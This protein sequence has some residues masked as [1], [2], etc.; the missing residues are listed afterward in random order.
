VERG[1]LELE[2]AIGT[3]CGE[4][5]LERGKRKG[6]DRIREIMDLRNIRGEEML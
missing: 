1:L 4:L 6:T 2:A 5:R 3:E